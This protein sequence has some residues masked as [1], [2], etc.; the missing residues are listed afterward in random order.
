MTTRCR[1]SGPGARCSQGG[2]AAVV[3][4][5][6]VRRDE[7]VEA[8]RAGVA[9]VRAAEPAAGDE[10]VDRARA[11]RRR[12][13]TPSRPC[14][15]SRMSQRDDVRRLLE[16][17]S[18]RLEPVAITGEQRQRR[19]VPVEPAG[20]RPSDPRSGTGDDDVPRG[21]DSHVFSR[22]SQFAG[23]SFGRDLDPPPLPQH[24]FLTAPSTG[25]RRTKHRRATVRGSGRPAGDV[26]EGGPARRIPGPLF[27]RASCAKR[28]LTAA[29]DAK[30]AI[31]G[32]SDPA[33]T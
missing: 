33:P 13:R 14:P 22:R 27:F 19:P 1:G 8:V 28:N 15:R 12:R 18:G 4:A 6:E 20:D 10:R 30:F 7:I 17:R 24:R 26:D 9:A 5:V 2:A 21:F 32:N 23:K 31:C 11:S 25:R 3:G 16:Q 29:L